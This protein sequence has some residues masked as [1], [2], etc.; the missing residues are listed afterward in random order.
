MASEARLSRADRR[1]LALLAFVAAGVVAMH[2]VGTTG[3]R[4]RATVGFA[5]L[6]L[7]F[8]VAAWAVLTSTDG[9]TRAQR[10][11]LG[12][13]LSFGAFV[14]LGFLLHTI[15]WPS[16][17]PFGG[18]SPAD[19]VLLVPFA[20]VLLAIRQEFITHFRRDDRQ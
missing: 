7:S 6:T 16:S 12:L 14:F 10:R 13:C 17:I 3:A 18:K 15:L 1:L 2:A 20:L 8:A 4:A 11:P 9:A 5:A 19:T